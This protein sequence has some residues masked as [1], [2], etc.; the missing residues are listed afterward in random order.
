MTQVREPSTGHAH[1]AALTKALPKLA[2]QIDVLQ[3]W[4]SILADRLLHGGRLLAAGNGGS[5]AQAQ[6]LTAEI[7]GRYC[8]ERRPLSAVALHTEPS[9]LTA[10]CNDYGL[11]E[12]FARQVAAHGRAGD[13]CILLSTS[14]SSRNVVA[15]AR[16]ARDLDVLTWAIT[17]PA[18]NPLAAI[19]DEALCLDTPETSTVQ[20]LHLVAIHLLCAAMDRSVGALG[21]ES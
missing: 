14:G 11:E 17:G 8:N 15:A 3:R 7:V 16:R 5:A 10:I 4:G 21:R 1:V 13:I 20:E 18:P 6:H 19:C 2:V 9:A 12:A